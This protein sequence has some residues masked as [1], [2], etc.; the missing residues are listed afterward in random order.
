MENNRQMELYY[1][2]CMEN[3]KKMELYSPWYMDNNKPMKL[4]SPGRME[5]KREKW[6]YISLSVWKI[7]RN[8]A[9]LPCVHGK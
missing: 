1:P 7:I 3:N 6:S 2:G 8:G 4:Y 5:N 9:V